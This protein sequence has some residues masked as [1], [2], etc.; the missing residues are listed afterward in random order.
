[1]IRVKLGR[2][3]KKTGVGAQ[4]W[5]LPASFRPDDAG[6]P[7]AEADNARLEV[8]DAEAALLKKEADRALQEI[9]NFTEATETRDEFMKQ[10]AKVLSE[11]RD[12]L[13]VLHGRNESAAREAA[14]ESAVAD[15]RGWFNFPSVTQGEYTIYARMI[16]KTLDLQW[17]ETVNVESGTV[18]IDLDESTA[19]GLSP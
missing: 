13:A 9:T 12:I 5:L 11:R 18:K 8:L 15:S 4:V 6:G 19:Q 17:L 10:R 7:S 14:L 2:M 16:D 1:M 3:K